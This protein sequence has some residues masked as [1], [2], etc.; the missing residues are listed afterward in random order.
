[1]HY[2]H[3]LKPCVAERAHRRP[4]APGLPLGEA[5]RA[6]RRLPAPGHPLGEAERAP[7]Q[8][9]LPAPGLPHNLG[10]LKL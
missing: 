7:R 8:P 1:M 5:E 6:H 10:S 9:P 4:P 3:V 2:F